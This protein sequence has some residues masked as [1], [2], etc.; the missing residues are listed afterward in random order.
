M[1]RIGSPSTFKTT[2]LLTSVTLVLAASTA[3]AQEATPPATTAPTAPTTAPTAGPAPGAPAPAQ[4]PAASAPT[5][6]QQPAAPTGPASDGSAQGGGMMNGG[7]QGGMMNGGMQGG[8][9][10]GMHDANS[11]AAAQ[12]AATDDEESEAAGN[13]LTWNLFVDSSYTYS[14]ARTGTLVP[15][16]RAWDGNSFSST[17]GR[18]TNNGF[19]LHWLGLDASYDAGE[20]AATGSLRFGT[21]VP[22]YYGANRSDLGTENLT[23]A[24]VSWRPSDALNFDL[25]QFNTI[26]GAEV[27]ESWRNLN[28]TRG[29][30]YFAMQ[31][32]HHTG[33]RANYAISDSI[34][35]TALVVN[36]ANTVVDDNDKPS[37]GLQIGVTPSDAF[38][39]YAGYLGAL[40]PKTDNDPFSHFFDVVATVSAGDF[41]LIL[42][43]DYDVD[44][45]TTAGGGTSNASF[46]GVSAAAG[47]TLNE[48]VGLAVRYEHLGDSD[49]VIYATPKATS[50][51][52]LTGT[53]DL[54]PVRGMTNLI[55]RWDNRMEFASERIFFDKDSMTTKKWFGS[56]L[57]VVVTTGN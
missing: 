43:G 5:T 52:T 48:M 23:Q 3:L 11:P 29:A 47:Y 57:G 46:Y 15:A 33:L 38:S 27:A 32:S 20:F 30:L 28:Y 13:G 21:A 4:Q 54:H 12:P 55:V 6:E 36:G 17:A 14:T 53:I 39:L 50:L 1:K 25:G 2:G 37:L 41:K 10:G 51:N 22:I 45:V 31:P 7:M 56:T 49:N 34:G 8:M 26:Y 40:E 35:L 24:Y 18:R 19:N 44:A 42:N 9:M 16:H